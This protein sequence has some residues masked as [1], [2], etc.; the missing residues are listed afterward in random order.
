[1]ASS[2]RRIV[3]IDGPAGAGKTSVSRRAAGRLGLAYL[4]TGAMFRAL[5]LALGPGGHTLPEGEIAARLAAMTFSLAGSGAETVLL[6]DGAPLPDAARTEEVGGW[7]SDLAVLPVVR[8]ILRRAQQALGQRADLLAE[9]RDMGTVVF[10][11]AARK[12]FLTASPEVR[13]SRRERQ[14]TA[15]GKPADY[16]A[17]LDAIR[18]R[19]EQD[20]HR[21]ASPLVP[22][23]DALII[24]TSELS[25]DM[26]VDRIVSA[27]SA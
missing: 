11:E 15:L 13:A 5:A 3:T 18:R 14:L 27:A 25:E 12:F 22:A 2:E 16:A 19:D 26:V 17:I 23:D 8:E 6:V 20:I 10:P 21:A 4:D 24:D 1:M 7:A 9:G